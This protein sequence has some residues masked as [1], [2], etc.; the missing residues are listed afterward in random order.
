MALSKLQ[1]S[2]LLAVY[3][4]MLPPAQRETAALYCDCDCTLS[5]V[6][7]DKGISRQ[8]VRDAVVKAEKTLVRLENERHIAQLAHDLLSAVEKE[9]YAEVSRIAKKFVGKE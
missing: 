5:E 1:L 8:A 6:A 4:A 2:Q 3:G 7:E 9:D